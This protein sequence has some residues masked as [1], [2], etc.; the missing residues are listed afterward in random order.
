MRRI[1]QNLRVSQ[2]IEAVF[3][4]LL[5]GF[6]R[7]E[8]VVGVLAKPRIFSGDPFPLRGL[9]HKH[10]LHG[11]LGVA[12]NH[13]GLAFLGLLQKLVELGFRLLDG[14]RHK[15]SMSRH[16]GEVNVDPWPI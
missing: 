9:L 16:L 8:N 11:G 3:P 7:L 4:Q 12:G 1:V 6:E 15:P 2:D 10:K 14:V 5:V 13:N